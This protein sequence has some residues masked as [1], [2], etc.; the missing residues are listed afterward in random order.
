[1]NQKPLYQRYNDLL[2]K[3]EKDMT[4]LQERY[5]KPDLDG[6]ELEKCIAKDIKANPETLLAS[7]EA[8]SARFERRK[9]QT[10]PTQ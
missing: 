6:P 5:E 9:K 1:M 10:Q 2:A 8:R 3:K 4:A 7:M